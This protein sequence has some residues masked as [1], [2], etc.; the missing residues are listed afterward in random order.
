MILLYEISFQ[1]KKTVSIYCTYIVYNNMI[2]YEF[3]VQ[4]RIQ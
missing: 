4:A 1:I 2:M 3:K